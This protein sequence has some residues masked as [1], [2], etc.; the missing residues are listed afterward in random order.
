M[1]HRHTL[2]NA[3]LVSDGGADRDTPPAPINHIGLTVPDIDAAIEFY[4]DVLGFSVISEPAEVPPDSGHFADLFVDI[5]NEYDGVR[6][7]HLESANG[8]GFELFEYASTEDREN[9]RSNIDENWQAAPGIHH[10]AVTHPNIE[11][12]IDRLEAAGGEQHSAQWTLIPDQPYELVY[13]VDPWGNMWEVFN[14]SY[15]Q[16]FAN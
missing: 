2:D 6:Q 4:T 11:E 15:A 13:I 12:L 3:R 1:A 9:P 7:S 8:V 16:F 5:I 14:R 10:F